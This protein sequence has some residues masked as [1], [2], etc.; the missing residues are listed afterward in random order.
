MMAYRPSLCMQLCHS[1][2]TVIVG[3]DSRSGLL[4]GLIQSVTGSLWLALSLMTIRHLCGRVSKNLN[5]YNYIL[6]GQTV[7]PPT[8][9]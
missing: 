5:E 3:V 8:V 9:V 6:A 4:A 2:S 7:L 1:Y